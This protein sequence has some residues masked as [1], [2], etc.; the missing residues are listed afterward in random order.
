MDTNFPIALAANIKANTKCHMG[1]KG[2]VHP[3]YNIE[4]R[5]KAN[6]LAITIATVDGKS[7]KITDC[8]TNAY[9]YISASDAANGS[10]HF[11][12]NSKSNSVAYI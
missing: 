11:A 4:G 6:H 5:L 1:S 10:S 7:Y 12:P 9:P 2:W 3:T 8:R